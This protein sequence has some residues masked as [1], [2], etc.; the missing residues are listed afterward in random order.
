MADDYTSWIRRAKSSLAISKIKSGE[1]IVYEDL[2]FQAQQAVEKA[3]KGLLV[4]Y[5][6]EPEK[7]HNLVSLIK[8]VSKLVDI[9]EVVNEVAI[10]NN[11]AVQT[12]Y[13]GAYSPLGEEEYNY[14]IMTAEKCIKWIEEKIKYPAP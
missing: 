12:R 8:E 7:T 9:P 13:P 11:Y 5:N 3:L 6:I 4:F 2:C 1:Y 10:L 14:A